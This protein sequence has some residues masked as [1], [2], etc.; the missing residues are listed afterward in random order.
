MWLKNKLFQGILIFFWVELAGKTLLN[1][2]NEKTETLEPWKPF[3]FHLKMKEVS[4]IEKQVQ[5]MHLETRKV[6]GG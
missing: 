6:K 5:D 1:T 2:E 4:I 3:L